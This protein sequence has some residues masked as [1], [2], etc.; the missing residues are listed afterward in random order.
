MKRSIKFK[1]RILGTLDTLTVAGIL[2]LHLIVLFL[3]ILF[4]DAAFE[5]GDDVAA[6]IITAIIFL[7][8]L[9][10]IFFY[11]SKILLSIFFQKDHKHDGLIISKKEF[12]QLYETINEIRIQSKCPKIHVIALDYSNNAYIREGSKFGFALWKKRYLVIGV[13]LLLLLNERELKGVI[14]HECGH[15]SRLHSRSIQRISWKMKGLKKYLDKLNKKGKYNSIIGRVIKKYLINLNNLYYQ[16]SKNHEL[17][18]DIIA[19]KVVSKQTLINA[20]I[21]MEF[22]D[23]IFS[24]YFWRTI[25]EFNKNDEKVIEDIYFM[26]ERAMK[27]N[28][29]IPEEV[30]KSFLEGIRNY[31]SLPGSTHPSI[32]ERAKS[33]GAV[34]PSLEGKFNGDLISVFKD[35]YESAIS[36]LFKNEAENILRNMSIKWSKLSAERWAEYYKYITGL[37]TSLRDLEAAE[38]EKVLEDKQ[39]LDKGLIIEELEGSDV[40]LEVFREAVKADTQ[41]LPAKFHTARTLLQKGEEEGVNIFK[42]VMEE[43]V[44]LIP[45]CCFHLV[46]YYLYNNNRTEA[47]NYY[48][49]AV[50]FMNTNE[51]AADER[52]KLYL[53]DELLPH[54]LS[55]KTLEKIKDEFMQYKEIKKAYV[56]MKKLNLTKDFPLYIIAIKYK[57][58]LSKEKVKSIADEILKSLHNEEILPWNLKIVPLNRKNIN[59]EYGADSI[60]GSR[61]I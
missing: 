45:Q 42:A 21:K 2:F 10:I 7:L 8:P 39:W 41:N 52:A 17:E 47:I 29:E 16:L 4:M 46:N 1:E 49:Y 22:Y 15:L 26:M 58:F 50:D 28:L 38:K 3:I 30:F 31:N 13:P 34:I 23:G 5:P 32:A 9:A 56:V 24:N 37:K 61:I 20:L 57:R 11:L 6:S 35:Y 60:I 43:D 54:D 55:M 44:Q 53:K 18:A 14:A 51:E 19:A 27:G 40:A 33:L 12:P 25:T 36:N 59:I 48:N